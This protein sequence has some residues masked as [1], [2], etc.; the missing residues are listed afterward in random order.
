MTDERSCLGIRESRELQPHLGRQLLNSERT[1]T[2]DGSQER[3][4][5][6]KSVG[7]V[8]LDKVRHD[9]EQQ[10]TLDPHCAMVSRL[11]RYC[12]LGA[13]FLLNLALTILNKIVL[14]KF[15]Y[16]NLL[17]AFH[18]SFAGMGCLIMK[19][20]GTITIR[21]ISMSQMGYIGCFSGLYT[22][23]IATSNASL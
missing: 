10:S 12:Y 17:T 5:R 1:T 18:A 8:D 19:C 20:C 15:S 16:P 4:A 6:R 11:E 7:R 2:Y 21:P 13:Y 9:S 23:N 22:L 14:Q 3:A